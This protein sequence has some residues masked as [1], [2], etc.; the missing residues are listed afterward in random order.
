MERSAL[1]YMAYTSTALWK[2]LSK[3]TGAL[4]LSSDIQDINLRTI[5]EELLYGCFLLGN[6]LS[7]HLINN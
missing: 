5:A 3:E 1:E 6:P 7:N 2:N 4:V